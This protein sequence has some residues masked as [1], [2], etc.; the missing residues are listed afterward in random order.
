MGK[1][2]FL[3]AQVR[4]IRSQMENWNGVRIPC[5][6]DTMEGEFKQAQW[7][8]FRAH[9][10]HCALAGV[11][12]G[13]PGKALRAARPALSERAYRADRRVQRSAAAKRHQ[14]W[15]VDSQGRKWVPKESSVLHAEAVEFVPILTQHVQGDCGTDLEELFAT[16]HTAVGFNEVGKRLDFLEAGWEALLLRI[17]ECC[18]VVNQLC[19]ER[20]WAVEEAERKARD[21]QEERRENLE[22]REDL[23]TYAFDTRDKLSVGS[24]FY[25]AIPSEDYEEFRQM[26]RRA[27][28]WLHFNKEATNAQYVNKLRKLKH[29]GNAIGWSF[30]D[31]GL[32]KRWFFAIL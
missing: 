30:A 8:S 27:I 6:D 26:V 3:F 19:V 31:A 14:P 16:S 2:S 5:S 10:R 28:D 9:R 29:V 1:Y 25:S 12:E 17:D 18:K 23:K 4:V 24:D 15:S 21:Q 32:R 7:D 11:A 22:K 13:S 20:D